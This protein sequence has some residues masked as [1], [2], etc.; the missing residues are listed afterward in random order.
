MIS[1]LFGA[2]LVKEGKLTEAQLETVFET[3]RKVRVKLGLIAVSEKLMTTQQSDEVN[4]LQAIVDKRFGDIA[5]EKGYLTEEQV[6]R[7]LGLQGNQY[8]SFVQSIVDND[9]MQ[10]DDIESALAAYQNENGFTL[11]DIESLKSGD[12]D[13][14]IPLFLPNN[15]T[16]YQTEHILVCIRTLIRLIDSEIYVGKGFVTDFY[17]APYFAL[18]SLDG[19][20]KASM[21]FSGEGNNILKI[22]DAFAGESFDKVDEDSLDSVAEF[23][24]CV[25]GLFAT[26]VNS[27]FMIDMLP[28]E[29]STSKAMF[30][31]KILVLPVYVQG[32]KVDLISSFGDIINK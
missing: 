15:I 32:L 7:L 4:R 5:V 25:N 22:A 14:I 18:Q 23:I 31:G 13:R 27:S 2:Y 3:M 16:E 12:S 11:T 10:M 17:E 30:S 9:F 8:L 6:S 20:N 19:D 26:K 29:Y 1:R 28:P 24:N 21:A